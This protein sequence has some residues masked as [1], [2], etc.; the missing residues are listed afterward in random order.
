MAAAS[1][2]HQR[3]EGIRRR[4]AAHACNRDIAEAV[5]GEAG[6]KR[7]LPRPLHKG[8]SVALAVRSRLAVYRLPSGSQGLSKAQAISCPRGNPASPAD[9]TSR[10]ILAEIQN[11]RAVRGGSSCTGARRSARAL[12]RIAGEPAPGMGVQI[13]AS[14]NRLRCSWHSGAG[15]CAH[16]GRTPPRGAQGTLGQRASATVTR[17]L[18][19]QVRESSAKMAARLPYNLPR[20]VQIT[21]YQ[22]FAVVISSVFS[23]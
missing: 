18:S 2:P 22:P 23:G 10:H 12:A 17:W 3:G 14:D 15:R 16:R 20:S 11:R 9:N 8:R 6:D 1:V 5:V 4:V 21:A 7:N 19:M 13:S